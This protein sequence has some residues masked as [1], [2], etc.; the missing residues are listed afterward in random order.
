VL[1][2][3]IWQLSFSYDNCMRIA[4]DVVMVESDYENLNIELLKL[5]LLSLLPVPKQLDYFTPNTLNFSKMH[6]Y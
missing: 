5:F 6:Y 2:G 1:N 4:Q 3:R